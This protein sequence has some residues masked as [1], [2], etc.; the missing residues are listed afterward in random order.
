MDDMF[1]VFISYKDNKEYIISPN[2][3]NYNLD[4]FNLLQIKKKYYHLK[5]I[6]II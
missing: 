4:I 6:K 2:R 5:D 1:E 3:D